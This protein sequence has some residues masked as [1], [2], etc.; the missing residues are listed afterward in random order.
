MA[1]ALEAG[2]VVIGN[3][4]SG[5]QPDVRLTSTYE[6]GFDSEE[7]RERGMWKVIH[8]F[9]FGPND[10]FVYVDTDGM[11]R[12]EDRPLNEAYI[13]YRRIGKRTGERRVKA[14]SIAVAGG[15]LLVEDL[16]TDRQQ[17]HDLWMREAGAQVYPA[18]WGD[19]P[20]LNSKQ[21]WYDVRHRVIALD[22]Q[23]PVTQIKL[24]ASFLSGEE[25]LRKFFG[26]KESPRVSVHPN[27]YMSKVDSH[28][29]DHSDTF[30]SLPIYD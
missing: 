26:R 20:G 15:N 18:P 27:G 8:N 2:Q 3:P 19:P 10:E 25:L 22:G 30:Y 28:D 16:L 14:R 13:E 21:Q 29:R 12:V 11:V 17:A 7:M 4:V 5:G 24:Q 6:Y 9:G 23:N 1:I